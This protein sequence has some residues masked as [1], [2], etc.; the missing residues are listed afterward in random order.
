[1]P[2]T[3]SIIA[4]S[5]I[6]VPDIAQHTQRHRDTE[7]HRQTDRQTDTPQPLHLLLERARL[8]SHTPAQYR[9]PRRGIPKPVL[10]TT[11][12]SSPL[13]STGHRVATS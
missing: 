9:T 8:V 13:V 7:T 3:P 5:R 6:P 12:S 4:A 1:M 2:V 10:D 11:R